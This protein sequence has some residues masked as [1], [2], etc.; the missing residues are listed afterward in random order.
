MIVDWRGVSRSGMACTGRL[1]TD[2]LE[3]FV[4]ARFRTGW[5]WLQV[6]SHPAGLPVGGINQLHGRRG[7]WSE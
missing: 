6:V 5:R 4:Q 7:W 1:E 3:A 2:D